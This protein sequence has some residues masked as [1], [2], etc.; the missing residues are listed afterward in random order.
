MS[1]KGSLLRMGKRRP[2]VVN[3]DDAVVHRLAVELNVWIAGTD[4]EIRETEKHVRKWLM[5][6]KTPDQIRQRHR[7]ILD[8]FPRDGEAP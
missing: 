3:F 1:N 4:E 7:E 5:M 2:K 6:G 8:S